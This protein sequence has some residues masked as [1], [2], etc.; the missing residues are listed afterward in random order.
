MSLLYNDR[1]FLHL[2][3]YWFI[4]LLPVFIIFGRGSGLNSCDSLHFQS[5]IK[6]ICNTGKVLFYF[7]EIIH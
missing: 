5:E 6:L 2:L 4:K 1:T 3:V 7:S